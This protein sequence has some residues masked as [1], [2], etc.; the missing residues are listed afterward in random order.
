MVE[1]CFKKKDSDPAA[2]MVYSSFPAKSYSI[3]PRPISDT[4]L[5]WNAPEAGIWFWMCKV[6]ASDC[7]PRL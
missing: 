3:L 1:N 7:K 6:S 2:C 4:L 5:A